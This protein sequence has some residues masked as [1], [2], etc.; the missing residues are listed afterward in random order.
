MQNRLFFLSN[1]EQLRDRKT[2]QLLASVGTDRMRSGDF[3]TA[4]RNIFDPDSRVYNASGV[5]RIRD[6]VPRECDPGQPP[7]SGSQQLFE[8]FPRL[9][10]SESLGPPGI[11]AVV[12]Q[13]VSPAWSPAE[14]TRTVA[15]KPD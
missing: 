15:A 14:R 4:G 10:W 11:A 2:T 12:A 9:N 13:D 3:S 1:W 7:Q 8:F 5:S 6:P